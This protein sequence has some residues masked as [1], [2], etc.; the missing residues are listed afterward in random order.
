[1][2]GIEGRKWAKTY[3]GTQYK[4][5]CCCDR[6]MRDLQ[7]HT[8]YVASASPQRQSECTRPTVHFATNPL[9]V[10]G[11]DIEARNLLQVGL[12]VPATLGRLGGLAMRSL[13]LG[14]EIVAGSRDADS[15]GD[16]MSCDWVRGTLDRFEYVAMGVKRS[17][18]A[19][20]CTGREGFIS[21]E[22]VNLLRD[23]T[24][25]RRKRRTWPRQGR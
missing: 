24:T 11:A 2:S 19:R 6:H 12:A 4:D 10:R 1:M 7:E 20:P 5:T 15:L 22:T 9:G 14:G 21:F 25:Y 23:Y 13:V 3:E 8:T 18:C 16:C 17:V